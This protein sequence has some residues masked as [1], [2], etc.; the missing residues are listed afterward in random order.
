MEITLQE[1]RKII[2][3]LKPGGAPGPDE[4]GASL[5]QGL[6]DI[7]APALKWI[8]EKSLA[9]GVVPEDWRIANVT[10]IFKK[11]SKSDLRNYRPVSFTSVRG[12]IFEAVLR[13]ILVAHFGE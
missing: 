7:M 1:I 13:D 9:E 8:F 11:G 10:P 12:K 5:L 6:E 4:I 3:K 2:Q